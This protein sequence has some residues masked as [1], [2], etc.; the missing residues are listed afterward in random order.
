M[1]LVIEE[2]DGDDEDEELGDA[3]S[4]AV[5]ELPPAPDD[6]EHAPRGVQIDGR[7][8]SDDSNE[9]E[10][11]GRASARHPAQSSKRRSLL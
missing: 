6:D 1:P 2:V 7:R 3:P 9:S 5:D 8:C 4:A 11:S 10:A